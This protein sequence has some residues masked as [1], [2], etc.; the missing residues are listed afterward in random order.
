MGIDIHGWIERKHESKAAERTKWYGIVK[1]DS[2]FAADSGMYGCLFG[3]GN[4]FEFEPIVNLR[5]LPDD[6]SQE[7]INDTWVGMSHSHTWIT[8]LEIE[9]IDW[10][11]TSLDASKFT[12]VDEKGQQFKMNR[13]ISRRENLQ[14]DKQ[15]QY[16][17][18]RMIAFSDNFGSKNIRL[19]VYFDS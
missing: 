3:V 10:D 2:F 11:E 13:K 8:Q 6:A 12:Y 15:W 4:R 18:K 14:W 19:V 5:G 1:I 17:F 9:N 16:L 7:V